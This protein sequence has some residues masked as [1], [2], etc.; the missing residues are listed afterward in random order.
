[1][2]ERE[3]IP[4]G[5]VAA[6]LGAIRDALVAVAVSAGQNSITNGAGAADTV[7]AS[8]CEALARLEGASLTLLEVTLDGLEDAD[9]DV[10]GSVLEFPG[11]TVRLPADGEP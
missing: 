10:S 1:M 11:G 5:D 4:A 2:A 8:V 3:P 7:A 6:E 9:G